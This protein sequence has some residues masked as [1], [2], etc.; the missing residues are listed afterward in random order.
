MPLFENHTHH[1]ETHAHRVEVTENR[2]PTIESVKLLRELEA[3]ARARIIDSVRVDDCPVDIVLHTD[4]S[5]ER[6]SYAA[7]AIFSIGGQKQ[8]VT[9]ETPS[10]ARP[11]ELL[12]LVLP[13]VAKSIA[14]TILRGPMLAM[15][16]HLKACKSGEVKP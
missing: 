8:R 15:A 6:M 11:E 13:A 5:L 9:V 3:E 12:E 2:A 1:L 4:F 16:K 10:C 14:E 7:A